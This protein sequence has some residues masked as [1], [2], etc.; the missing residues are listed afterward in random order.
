MAFYV[1]LHNSLQIIIERGGS[2]VGAI[3]GTEAEVLKAQGFDTRCAGLFVARATSAT[4]RLKDASPSNPT[5][6]FEKLPEGSLRQPRRNSHVC[7]FL[8][9]QRARSC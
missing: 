9:F 4:A 6:T 2:L 5:R 7:F 8:P 3:K 1:A